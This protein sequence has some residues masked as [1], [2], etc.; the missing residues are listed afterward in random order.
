MTS[1]AAARLG[2]VVI[3]TLASAQDATCSSLR[4]IAH[5]PKTT[6]D[7]SGYLVPRATGPN[8]EGATADGHSQ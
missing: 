7:D 8:R 5:H 1:F 3:F 6:K 2:I 4:K